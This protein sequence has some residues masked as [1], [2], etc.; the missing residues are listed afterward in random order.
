MIGAAKYWVGGTMLLAGVFSLGLIGVREMNALA[1]P[2]FDSGPPSLSRTGYQKNRHTRQVIKKVNGEYRFD[3]TFKDHKGRDWTWS[4]GY[5]I[6]ETNRDIERFGLPQSM[7]QPY[8]VTPEVIRRRKQTL[9]N[10]MFRRRGNLLLPNYSKMISFYSNYTKPIYELLKR[11]VPGGSRNERIETL[12][13]FIQDIPY[14]IPP[15]NVGNRVISGIIPPPQLFTE[16]WGDCDSKAVLFSTIMAHDPDYEVIFLHVPKHMFSAVRGV[17]R[18]YQQY[19]NY[20]GKKYIIAETVGPGRI[21]FGKPG[22]DVYRRFRVEKISIQRPRADPQPG[23]ISSYLK[24]GRSFQGAGPQIVSDRMRGNR[25]ELVIRSRSPVELIAEL[26]LKRV[27]LKNQVQIQKRGNDFLVTALFDRPGNYEIMVYSRPKGARGGYGFALKFPFENRKS[28]P[29]TSGFLPRGGGMRVLSK[30]RRGNQVEL[31][32]QSR[33]PMELVAE[34]HSKRGLLKNQVFVQKRGNN[35]LLTALFDQPG[36]YEI[37]LYSRPKGASGGYSFALKFFFENRKSYPRTSGFPLTYSAFSKLD[38][39]L[40][41]PMRGV[42]RRGAS[43]SFRLKVPGATSVAVI[44]G[45]KWVHLKKQGD[46]FFGNVRLQGNKASVMA[47]FPSRPRSFTGLLV[48]R[49]R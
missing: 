18:P 43:E 17:P 49:V 19:I 38:G 46:Q 48:Y 37:K 23:L 28:Y 45:Q 29:R 32:I 26:R 39:L 20:R 34:L 11:T 42:L 1:R 41:S 27:T 44:M 14:G 47:S 24:S 5:D 7:F 36:N 31:V 8:M 40:E 25:I 2:Y 6:R 21:N 35:F 10:G 22:N 3:W 16:G 4:W 30:A 33:S 12:M 15:G 13:K 9:R